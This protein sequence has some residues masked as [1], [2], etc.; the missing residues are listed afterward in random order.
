M[1]KLEKELGKRKSIIHIQN[2][3]LTNSINIFLSRETEKYVIG[4]EQKFYRI[5]Y[6]L[7]K[8]S[9]DLVKEIQNPIKFENG[10]DIDVREDYRDSIKSSNP[11]WNVK[12]KNVVTRII[13][14]RYNSLMPLYGIFYYF[15]WRNTNA[16]GIDL[17]K[18]EIPECPLISNSTTINSVCYKLISNQRSG[19]G[20]HGT[21]TYVILSPIHGEYKIGEWIKIS[22][23]NRNGNQNMYTKPVFVKL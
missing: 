16:G 6:L 12:M 21:Q 5:H 10:L 18:F 14:T 7:F 13:P 22:N 19:G 2:V 11:I 9:K 20:T 23:Q 8:I 1:Q 17:I 4:Y 15:G 3:F